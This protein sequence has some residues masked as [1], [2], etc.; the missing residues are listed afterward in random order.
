MTVTN[1]KA[2]SPEAVRRLVIDRNLAEVAVLDVRP[3]G[4]FGDAHLLWANSVPLTTLEIEILDRVPRLDTPVV[5][6]GYDDADDGI[7]SR[8]AAKMAVMGY[9]NLAWLEGGVKAWGEAGFEIFSG[10]NVPS[11]AFGEFVEHTYDTPRIPAE[12]LK[13]MMDE[14]AN[15]VVLDSRPMSEYH[16]MNIPLGV[17]VP[18]AELALRVHDLAPDPGTTVVVNCAGRTRS[19]IGCQSLRNAGIPNKVVALENGTMGWHLA[20]FD[21]EYGNERRYGTLSAEGLKRATACAD[22]VRKR[23]GVRMIDAETLA[24]WQADTARTT[25]LLDVRDPE[26][27]AAGHVPGSRPAPGG[28]LVQATDRYVGT[29]GARIVCV[30]DNAVR[31]TMTASWLVQ[32]GWDAVVLAPGALEMSEKGTHMPPRPALPSVPEI[33]AVALAARMIQTHVVDLGNSLSHRKSHIPGSRFAIR[34]N[35]PEN[36]SSLSEDRPIVLT[37]GDGAIAAYAAADLIAAGIRREIMVLKGGTQAWKAAG[38]PMK[39]GFDNPLD[40][41]VDVWY[42]PYDMDDA[43]EGA[44]KQYLSWEVNL[45]A[46]IERDG[47]TDFRVFD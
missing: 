47:T 29:L 14:G 18:G 6:C 5:L 34:A 7:V 24:D 25:Y 19:I 8:A 16:A 15:M 40:N 38:L 21:L 20:G 2:L 10:V 45:V 31:A 27:F 41:S 9:S 37:S 12:D 28:Q 26:E 36:L 43:Q 30:D 42:R 17:D 1:A 33:E 32:I 22:H 13:R 4:T 11:K 39:G 46:Q 44:M 23:F 35:M 3:G